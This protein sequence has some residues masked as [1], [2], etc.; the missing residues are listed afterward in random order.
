[1]RS[2]LI[3]RRNAERRRRSLAD[4]C[5]SSLLRSN[6]P[7]PTTAS[8]S[9]IANM[10]NRRQHSTA[11]AR[12]RANAPSAISEANPTPGGEPDFPQKDERVSRLV[13]R[14][15][16][17]ETT[18]GGHERTLA[19]PAGVAADRREHG[20][21]AAARRVAV[22]KREEKEVEEARRKVIQSEN[23]S[24][25]PER[26]CPELSPAAFCG[27]VLKLG[28]YILGYYICRF[29]YDFASTQTNCQQTILVVC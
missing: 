7:P 20:V 4:A 13:Q 18:G 25:A 21:K 27:A 28:A 23:E 24:G 10:T 9:V 19:A 11:S 15:D 22:R 12:S 1:M 2:Q 29:R 17:C 26:A 6:S 16:V 14:E 8:S 3:F 5:P